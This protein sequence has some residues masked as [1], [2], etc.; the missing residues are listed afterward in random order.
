MNVTAQR[1]RQAYNRSDPR[2]P[3]LFAQ[4]QQENPPPANMVTGICT[5]SHFPGFFPQSQL[6][7]KIQCS[8]DRCIGIHEVA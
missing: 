4:W 8:R 2:F 5:I 7:T 6:P 3:D 1:V